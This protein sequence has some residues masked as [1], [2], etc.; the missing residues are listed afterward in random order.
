M[1]KIYEDIKHDNPIDTIA[2]EGNAEKETIF[3]KF[4]YCINDYVEAHPINIKHRDD[5]YERAFTTLSS[6][7]NKNLYVTG[8]AG[9]GY[10]SFI[11]G[12]AS[13]INEGNCPKDMSD[14]KLYEFN[15]LELTA[16]N[17]M[18]GMSIALYKELFDTIIDTPNVI[19]VFNNLPEYVGYGAFSGITFGDFLADYLP[20]TR[21]IFTSDYSSYRANVSKDGVFS[22]NINVIKLDN[23]GIDESIDCLKENSGDYLSYHHIS[24]SDDMAK[25]IVKMA[26]KYVTQYTLPG[27]AFHLLDYIGAYVNSHILSGIKQSTFEERLSQTVNEADSRKAYMNMLLDKAEQDAKEVLSRETHEVVAEDVINTLVSG[28]TNAP[29]SSLVDDELEKLRGMKDALSQKVIGQE[30]AIDRVVKTIQRNRLGVR[31]K[32]HTI[33]NFMFIGTSGCGKT[34]L[35]KQIAQYMFGNNEENLIRFDMSEFSDSFSVTKL[36]GAPPGYVGYDNGGMLTNAIQKNPYSII[37][38]DE[39]EKAHPAI[40]NVLLQLLDEGRLTDNVGRIADATNCLIIMT[41]NVGTRSAAQARTMIGFSSSND[42]EQEKAEMQLEIIKKEYE[43][44]FAPEFRARIDNMVVFNKLSRDVMCKIFDK[45]INELNDILESQSR[46]TLKIKDVL[47]D[48]IVDKA[49]ELDNGARPL[50]NL[51][52]DNIEEVYTERIIM[53]EVDLTQDVIEFDKEDID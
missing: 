25:R 13:R 7:S 5:E 23:L 10:T 9:S 47:K 3:D 20:K 30:E 44:K 24:M 6:N 1:A 34:E 27:S 52:K 4:G 43:E 17:P 28:F 37:L 35:C 15:L 18:P 16:S 19:C 39:I 21:I 2:Q 36:I 46:P 40:Y 8:D 42:K 48:K 53:G 51:I 49:I 38:F 14:V 12:L 29:I 45:C 33:G 26:D 32:K 50:E 11:R 22:D 41:S 31:K